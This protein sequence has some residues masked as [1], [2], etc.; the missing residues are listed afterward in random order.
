MAEELLERV[1]REIRER[2]REAQAAYEESRR[3]EQALVA[4]GP[5]S[6]GSGAGG[7]GAATRRRSRSPRAPAAKADGGSTRRRSRPRRSRTAPGANRERIVALVHERP[8]VTAAEIAQQ[9]GIGRSTVTTTLGRLVDAATVQRIELP[10]GQHGFR[11]H[12]GEPDRAAPPAPPASDA[13]PASAEAAPT[14][15]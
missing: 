2:M 15:D 6:G 11:A 7:D 9:T 1:L 10:G 12:E 4:L 13:A 8:G 5:A 3:L 14:P